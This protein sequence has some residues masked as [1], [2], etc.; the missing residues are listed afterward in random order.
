M[1][2]LVLARSLKQVKEI[3]RREQRTSG[4]GKTRPHCYAQVDEKA[5][6]GFE[7]TGIRS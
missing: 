3:E 2:R 7:H 5:E 6:L 1:K 4:G